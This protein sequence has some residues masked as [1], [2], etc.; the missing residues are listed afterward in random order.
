MCRW[1]TYR[2]KPV[3]LEELIFEPDYSLIDQSLRARKGATTTNGDGF[4]VGWYG[5]RR[6]PGLFREVLP[7]WND[8]N[9]RALAHQIQSQLFFAHVR[10][11][12]GTATMRANCHPFAVGPWLFMHNGQIGGYEMVRRALDNCLPDDLYLHRSGTTD[13]ESIFLHLLANGVEDDPKAAMEATIRTVE[14]CIVSAGMDE[15]FRMT[16]AFSD[17]QC[18]YAARYSTD[19][20]PPTLYYRQDE[21]GTMVVSEPHGETNR[22]WKLVAPSTFLHCDERGDVT[23]EPMNI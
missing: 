21:G 14:R 15:A 18:L 6:E 19:P 3:Y 17:G 13:S 1:L 23:L 20:D 22:G 11:S 8:G 12:T 7:A 16:T 9:L 5:N 2:G 4:G 10:A